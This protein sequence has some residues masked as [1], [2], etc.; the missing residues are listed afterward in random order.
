MQRKF[1]TNLSLLLFLNL[2]IKPFW[3]FG[4]DRTVQNLVGVEAFGFYFVVFNFSF[5]FNILLDLGITNFNNRNIAQNHHLLSKHFSGILLMKLLL[6]F[7]YLGV[8]FF[9]AVWKYNP[10]Q[11]K[12]LGV[13]AFNQFLISFILYLRSNISGLLMF[14]TD[15]FLSV[16]DRMLMI[17]FCGILLW[18]HVTSTPFR[19]E[20]FVYSQTA[21]YVFTAITALLIVIKKAKFKRLNWNWPF[22]LMIMK[23]SAPFA[24]L[25]LFMTFYNRLDPVMLGILLDKSKGNEQAGIYASGFRIFD[26]VN[27]IA[28][29]FSVL[30][31]PVFSKMIKHKEN[32]EQM[33]KLSFTMIITPAILI[34]L[35]SFFYSNELMALLYN[36]HLHDSAHVFQILM[37]GFIAVSATYIF[38]TLLTANGNLKE[39]NIIA[40]CGLLISF[41]CNFF[42][43]PKFLAIGSAYASLITQFTTAAVQVVLAVK[44][45]KLKPNYRYL[46]TLILYVVGVATFNILSRAYPVH[47]SFIPGHLSWIGGFLLMVFASVLLSVLL[48]LWSIGSL[49][50]I[51]RSER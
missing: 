29:L 45:F 43:I 27:M 28:Y 50:R 11:L 10:D 32:V 38:G 37:G 51:L 5:L 42:L 20:W 8:T 24:L 7:L 39:L 31:V 17:L 33:V 26:A 23:Q 9:V 19:I 21:A 6:A 3:V 34:A 1:L 40:C 16:L 49:L 35:G 22:F 4:I 12:L 47:L 30:L 36:A 41:S 13:L 46:L 2:L 18:G 44:V 14:K 15:S 48:K 25:V